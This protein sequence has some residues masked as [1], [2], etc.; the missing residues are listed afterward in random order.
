VK[1][2]TIT[3]YEPTFQPAYLAN[4]LVGLR[5]GANPLVGGKALV[6]GFVGRQATVSHEGY[7]P[8]PCPLG[9]NVVVG[10]EE[11]V[12]RPDLVRFVS[13]SYD[14]SC[15]ELR[16]RLTFATAA[17][18]VDVDV[19]TFCSRDLPPVVAQEVRLQVDR[20]C[21][22]V[23][24]ARMDPQG[25]P[26]R[27]RLAERLRWCADAVL[28]WEGREALSSCGAA[29]DC[30]YVG[31]D[32]AATRRNDWGLE[33][34][35]QL[36]EF[37]VNA[38]PGTPYVWRQFGA[39]VPSLMHSE[40]HWQAARLV[41]TARVMGFEE[42]RKGN[43]AAWAELWRARPVLVGADPRWQDAA[44]AAFFYVHSSVHPSMPAS[45]APFGLSDE[46][47]YHG[48]VFWDT[49][50]WMFP[51]TLM[52]DPESARAM[53]EYRFR[54][55]EGAEYNARLLGQRGLH[56]PGQTANSGSDV[57]TLWA[58]GAFN[59]GAGLGVARAFA[60]YVH[61]TGDRVFEREKAWP[62]LRGVAEWVVSAVRHTRRGYEVPLDRSADEQWLCVQNSA[63]TL[64]H[65]RL[66]LREASAMAARLGYEPP[67]LWR[68]IAERLYFPI[69]PHTNVL[70][71]FEGWEDTR[72]LCGMEVLAMY[73]FTGDTLGP[74]VDRATL[75]YYLARADRYL[76][77]P[78]FSTQ[79][80]VP[81]ARHRSRAAATAALEKGWLSR[82]RPPFLQLCECSTAMGAWNSTDVTVFV[83][84]C[85]SA[86][87]TLLWLMPGLQ[88]GPGEPA[89]WCVA[90]PALPDAWQAIEVERLWV[91]GRP[92]RLTARHGEPAARIEY[93]EE[94]ILP[95][96][97]PLPVRRQ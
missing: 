5:L 22:L 21:R 20:P 2:H 56:F 33:Q 44:D 42:L 39:L 82:L 3:A 1:T 13:Q 25:L 84:C 69:A 94:P 63:P 23:F 67:A 85:A 24:Q 52:T 30:E 58:K 18:K 36:T 16:S 92:A 11:L 55:R 95:I 87:H 60:Q 77:M 97:D 57:A 54:L 31:G 91:R 79:L 64:W 66:V 37:T 83:T 71:K 46:F 61:A 74:E 73:T 47:N 62:I 89:S 29:Y 88:W 14:F 65:M 96:R 50:G 27:P 4:G 19:V 6:N 70:L 72:E 34:D 26:G 7:N 45:V 90:P 51:A 8:A 17:A 80:A 81:F 49:E 48:H 38:R 53:L 68:E 93:R 10:T 35:L 76:G 40:P 41:E 86:V 32:L 59:P 9:G 15:G 12:K 78:M 75:E 28:W 43:R